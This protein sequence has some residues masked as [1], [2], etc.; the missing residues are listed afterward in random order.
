[1][2]VTSEYVYNNP[3][4]GKITDIIRKTRDEHDGKYGYDIK[5]RTMV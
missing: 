5:H 4:L 2:I 3:E 1:M